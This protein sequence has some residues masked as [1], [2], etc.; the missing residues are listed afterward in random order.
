MVFTP[1]VSP[2]VT[3]LDNQFRM[4]EYTTPGEYF[5]PLTSPALEAQMRPAQRSVYGPIRGSDTSDTAS[6]IEMD[7]DQTL[8][9]NTASGPN[10]RKSK[11]KSTSTS[12]KSTGRAVKQSPAMKPQTRSKRLSSTVIP[13]KEVD[14]VI[15]DVRRAKENGQARSSNG[16]L[17]LPYGQDSSEAESVSPEPLSEILMPPPATPRPGSVGRSPYLKAQTNG[18]QPA[19]QPIRNAPA[20]P[21]SL[22]KIQKKA[23]NG[24]HERRVL[25]ENSSRA[26]AEME[27]IME[28]IALPEATTGSKP[29]LSNLN[30]TNIDSDQATS[31]LSAQKVPNSASTPASSAVLPSPQMS[32]IASPGKSFASKRREPKT[33]GRGSKKRGSTISSQVSPALRPRIS[34]SIKPLLPEGSKSTR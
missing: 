33:G 1:L 29:I 31:T 4:P 19:P 30:T 3:P 14:E 18:S 27:R 8:N 34:P 25:E 20:T 21:A 10:L 24:A 22:M 9:G 32:A 17:S 23:V 16:K 28:G 7:I 15:E 11:R 12:T 13:P 26:E 5:S 2:A 6:P